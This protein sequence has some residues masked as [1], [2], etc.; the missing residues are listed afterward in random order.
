MIRNA[1]PYTTLKS[2]KPKTL[3]IFVYDLSFELLKRFENITVV[4]EVIHC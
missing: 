2:G 1:S 3:E 4:C